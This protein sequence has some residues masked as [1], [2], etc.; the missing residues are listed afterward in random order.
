MDAISTNVVEEEHKRIEES[1]KTLH[2]QMREKNEE[3]QKIKQAILISTGAKIALAKLLG[4][5]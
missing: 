2:D 3:I 5:D 4:S 1:L